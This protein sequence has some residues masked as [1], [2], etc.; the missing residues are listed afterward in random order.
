MSRR[1]NVGRRVNGILLLDKPVGYSSNQALQL[2]KRLFQAQKAGHAGALDPLATG[3]LP[4]CFGE[5]TKVSQFLL[6]ADKSYR[7]TAKLGQTTTTGDAEGEI[8]E[9]RPISGISPSRLLNVVESYHGK[10]LQ[11]P[12]MFSA[13]KYQGKPLYKLAR[14]GIEVERK[15]R[16][17]QVRRITVLEARHEFVDLEVHCSKGTYIRTLVEDIGSELGCGAHVVALRRTGVQP[18]EQQTLATLELLSRSAATGLH[19]LDAFL[20]PL[21]SALVGWPAVYLSE[22]S[23]YFVK[24]GQAVQVAKAPTQGYLRLYHKDGAFFGMGRI[25][26]DGKVA[27]KRLM[28]Q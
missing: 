16:P 13:L 27:P 24:C 17:V 12:P 18:Y 7:L 2:V 5:A 11:V 4:I 26:D 20:L 23:A 21:E 6:E 14:Q 10:I 8:L 1:R 28:N 15:A 19:A 25:Q 22:E 9:T 3:I